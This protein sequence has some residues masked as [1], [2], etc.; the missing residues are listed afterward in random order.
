MQRKMERQAINLKQLQLRGVRSKVYKLKVFLRWG[1]GEI[2]WYIRRYWG[3]K[4]GHEFLSSANKV[5]TGPTCQY[6]CV[7]LFVCLSVC[8]SGLF[9][10]ASNWMIY[11]LLTVVLATYLSD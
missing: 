8:V 3:R 11:W 4:L 7:C 6:L 10:K 1:W 5:S 9:F 2:N